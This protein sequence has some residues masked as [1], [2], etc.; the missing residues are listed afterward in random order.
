[1]PVNA[2]A[3]GIEI[4]LSETTLR[5]VLRDES[6]DDLQ[7]M[8]DI[9]DEFSDLVGPDVTARYTIEKGG[10]PKP[11]PATDTFAWVYIARE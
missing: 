6:L 9:L 7:D 11:V 10:R 4:R 1:V 8:E 2:V 3:I 5:F